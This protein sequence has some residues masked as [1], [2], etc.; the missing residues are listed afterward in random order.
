MAKI[1]FTFEQRLAGYK[2]A[3]AAIIEEFLRR[4]LPVRTQFTL[5]RECISELLDLSLK[6]KMF[7]S[8]LYLDIV[9]ARQKLTRDDYWVGAA[10]E[11][12]GTALLIHDDIIDRDDTRRS[13]DTLHH[14]FTKV[15]KTAN[16][17]EPAQFGLGA[18][19][20]EGDMAFFI[21]LGMLSETELSATV[22]RNILKTSYQELVTVSLGQLEDTRQ[23]SLAAAQAQELTAAEIIEMMLGKTASYTTCWPLGLAADRL[24]FNDDQKDDLLAYA[25]QLGLLFQLR[26]D[27]LGVFGEEDLTGKSNLN[28]LREGKKTILWQLLG[29][30]E[31]SPAEKKLVAETV[32]NVQASETELAAVKELMIRK[33]VLGQ[34]EELMAQSE[35]ESEELLHAAKLPRQ[36]K[37]RLMETF[38][39]LKNRA[40]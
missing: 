8:G 12:A 9:S 27:F 11:M 17:R 5:D 14:H 34:V 40:K 29:S 30:A 13:R 23:A 19:I 18:G 2:Q 1:S 10:I 24:Q 36:I 4:P 3:V 38:N 20:I 33:N 31:L 35:T 26:D 15:A 7:R 37:A 39:Y 6:G 21:L 28:D 25:E 22:L 16:L 32:G